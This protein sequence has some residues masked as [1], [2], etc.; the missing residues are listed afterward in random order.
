MAL[1]R[2]HAETAGHLFP[3]YRIRAITNGVHLDILVHPAF[4]QLYD[5][6]FLH[7]RHDP[8]MPVR[9]LEVPESEIW[10][11][12][13][14]ARADLAEYVRTATGVALDPGIPAIGFARRMTGYKRPLFLFEDL[15]RLLRIAEQHPFQ[16]I[17]A[18]KAHP[19]DDEGKEP[20]RRLPQ[21]FAQLRRRV[22][23][24]FL[25]NYD[26]EIAK[27][28]VAGCEIWLNTPLPPLEA[29]GTSGM[30]A[31]V[32]GVLNLS[33]LDGWWIEACVEGITGWAIGG[34]SSDG[35]GSV[36]P[37]AAALYDK[38]VDV[39][40]PLFHSDPTRWRWMMK[41]A[42]GNIGACFNSHRMMRRYAAEAYLR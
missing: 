14:A 24:V 23:C 26:M 7:W 42:I 5:S 37:N 20:I 27:L 13:R 6:H 40:L 17:M 15:D 35:P 28:L 22:T 2:R 8:E 33:V 39:V 1:P 29:S 38:L 11:C 36:P 19:R 41:Q 34:E 32:N 25:P 21:I 18:G 4:A 3:G 31:A 9:L 10:E 30:K 12:H 16:L